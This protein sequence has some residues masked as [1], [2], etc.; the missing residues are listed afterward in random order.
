MGGITRSEP[1]FHL[2]FVSLVLT[3]YIWDF[4]E[5]YIFQLTASLE[6]NTPVTIWIV[7]YLSFWLFGIWEFWTMWNKT[8]RHH[9]G[10]NTVLT[11]SE[12]EKEP[13]VQSCS[14]PPPHT[15]I[16]HIENMKTY[17]HSLIDTHTRSLP[18]PHDTDLHYSTNFASHIDNKCTVTCTHAHTYTHNSCSHMA[19]PPLRH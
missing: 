3:S 5:I 1:V 18:S 19:F 11:G 6:R 8:S 17:K 12:L 4:D 13:F 16:P 2:F 9:K 14:S 15:H 10:I 7:F